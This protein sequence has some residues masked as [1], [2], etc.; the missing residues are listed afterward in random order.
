M[1]VEELA[2]EVMAPRLHMA[3]FALQLEECGNTIVFEAVTTL[4]SYDFIT[5]FKI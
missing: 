4:I 2:E 3:S 1:T 5:Y